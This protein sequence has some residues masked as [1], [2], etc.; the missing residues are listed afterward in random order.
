MQLVSDTVLEEVLQSEPT[1]P[2]IYPKV[3][4]FNLTSPSA[5]TGGHPFDHYKALR[6]NAPVSWSPLKRKARGI[7]SVTR[8]EDI[9]TVE[10][11]PHIYSSERGSINMSMPPKHLRFPKRC[12]AAYGN[13]A[14]TKRLLHPK[15]CCDIAG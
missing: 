12:T 4:T 3:G 15:I 13:A 14:A 8:Y 7:W 9:K 11:A 1:Y 5:F 10:L 2:A 6:E